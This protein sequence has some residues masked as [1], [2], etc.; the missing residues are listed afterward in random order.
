METSENSLRG[1]VSVA[2]ESEMARAF[3][4]LHKVVEIVSNNFNS[5]ESRISPILRSELKAENIGKDSVS[6]YSSVLAQE[7]DGVARRI[8]N[9]CKRIDEVSK[10]VEL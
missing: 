1:G 5:L 2:R 4:K 3:S 10:R 7:I 9:L 6:E 8:E